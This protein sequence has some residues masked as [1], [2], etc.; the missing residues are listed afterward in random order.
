MKKNI[1]CV[2]PARGGSKGIKLKNIYKVNGKELILYTLDFIKKVKIFADVV[3][4]TDHLKIKNVCEK[5][6]FPVPFL[7]PKKLAGDKI[8]DI[9]VL[10]HSLNRAEKIYNKKYE[11]I[12]MLQPTSPIR[13]PK[14]LIEG[15][16][17]FYKFQHDSLWSVSV[18][19]K[20]YH[21]F[22][23]LVINKNKLSYFNKKG[24][25]IIARQQLDETFFR[26]GVFYILS[27]DCI[28]KNKKILGK[29]PG[30]FNITGDFFN[31]DSLS[32]IKLF[33]SSIKK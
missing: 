2:V 3:I 14:D 4:S 11:T 26:N 18:V 5:N 13:N 32:D 27:R 1:L 16:K 24:E 31:I 10:T 17:K 29:K 15:L 28:L 6:K 12:V 9:S 25:K 7:R 23:Q 8:S 19:E 30:Y 22:K 21:P 20:K 33:S